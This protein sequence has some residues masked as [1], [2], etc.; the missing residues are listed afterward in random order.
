[1]QAIH[2]AAAIGVLDVISAFI[3]AD[4]AVVNATIVNTRKDCGNTPLH[5]ATSHG[6]AAVI[7]LLLRAGA[8]MSA[9]YFM[10][11]ALHEGVA[12]G[13]AAVVLE[14]LAFLKEQDDDMLAVGAALA[15]RDASGITPLHAACLFGELRCCP[16]SGQRDLPLESYQS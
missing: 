3:Q 2:L 6:H 7:R 1:V 15:Q 4:P 8:R 14:F 9:G 16:S 12:S 11:T 13:S 10:R 5:L